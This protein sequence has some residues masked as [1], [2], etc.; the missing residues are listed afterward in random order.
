MFSIENAK[1]YETTFP[2]PTNEIYDE[3]LLYV[4]ISSYIFT[5]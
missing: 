2:I 5:L 1:A 4:I 3:D